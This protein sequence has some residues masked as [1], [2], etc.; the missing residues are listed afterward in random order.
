M[1]SLPIS[2]TVKTISKTGSTGITKM[3]NFGRCLAVL[4]HVERAVYRLRHRLDM[5]SHDPQWRLARLTISNDTPRVELG[6]SSLVVPLTVEH[7]TPGSDPNA[8]VSPEKFPKPAFII[9][10]FGTARR[11]SF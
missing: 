5:T 9:Y 3:L 11:A 8:S 4:E 10:F 2:F 1:H 6:L 7:V